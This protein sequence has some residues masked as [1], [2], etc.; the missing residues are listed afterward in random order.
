MPI[1][2]FAQFAGTSLWFAVNAILKDL[3]QELPVVD[4]FLGNMTSA[5]QLGFVMGTLLYALFTIS[6]RFSPVKV[7]MI[8]GLIAALLNLL[9]LLLAHSYEALLLIRFGVGFFL[10]G[11]YP[12]GMKIMS[13]W[14]NQG[15]GRALGYLVGALVLGTSFGHLLTALSFHLAWQNSIIASSVLASVG[16]IIVGMFINDGPYRKKSGGFRPR[17]IQSAFANPSF[18]K[19]A[20]GYFGH[21]FEL[22]T[23]WA[24][25]PVILQTFQ[26]TH[27]SKLNI[28]FWSFM[29]IAAG[30]VGCIV[31][32][33]LS[34]WIKSQHLAFYSLLISGICCVVSPWAFALPNSIFLVFMLIW[35]ISV[36][37]DSPQFST[38]ISQNTLPETRASALTIVNSIG[39]GITILS[40]LFTQ[41]LLKEW[42]SPWVYL[43]LAI[44][45]IAG[46]TAMRN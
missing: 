22:Y 24:F 14:Y 40:I 30:V 5:V 18:R 3:Q 12:V 1:V 34:K 31:T 32:A 38:L 29:I 6:D 16:A 28:P 19:Y 42:H 25:I 35:G 8:S 23:F 37:A 15:L 13:D 41:Y 46:L 17:A 45:P 44:G 11:V 33:E 26:D 7:F 21:M 36:V 39:F 4:N 27:H 10:A 20:W 9:T 43:P 2:V